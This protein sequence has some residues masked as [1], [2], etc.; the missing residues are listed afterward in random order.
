MESVSD[1][2]N[3]GLIN[4][5]NENTNTNDVGVVKKN[6]KT[7][8]HSFRG[9]GSSQGS[10][11]KEELTLLHNTSSSNISSSDETNNNNTNSRKERRRKKSR[12][13]RSVIHRHQII[14][15]D[16]ERTDSADED[17]TTRQSSYPTG[18]TFDPAPS[19]LKP[20]SP[21]MLRVGYG[22]ELMVTH[23]QD[24]FT[25]MNSPLN[26]DDPIS[27]RQQQQQQQQPLQVSL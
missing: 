13:Q 1:D 15:D 17:Y 9:S 18:I 27:P 3:I 22:S 10:N 7:P 2:N 21:S 19:I 16:D 24:N 5:I 23:S 6:K 26:G 12:K 8:G 25:I 14:D 11:I 4:G 20:L